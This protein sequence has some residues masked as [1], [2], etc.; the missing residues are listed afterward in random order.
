SLFPSS[1]SE[2]ISRGPNSA[3]THAAFGPLARSPP[4][5]SP[6]RTTPVTPPTPP[7]PPR[8]PPEQGAQTLRASAAKLSA[9]PQRFPLPHPSLA[10]SLVRFLALPPCLS[11][12]KPRG[13]SAPAAFDAFTIRRCLFQHPAL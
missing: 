4:S 1:Q 12:K 9:L 2:K 13:P 7:M 6:A 11:K 10:C 5:S 3:R 8:F